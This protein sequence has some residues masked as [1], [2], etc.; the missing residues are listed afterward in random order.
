MADVVVKRKAKKEAENIVNNLQTEGKDADQLKKQLQEV[1]NS[2]GQQ[3][4]KDNQVGIDNLKDEL[5]K[6]VSDEEYSQ[7]IAG[8]VEKTLAKYSIKEDELDSKVEED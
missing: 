3:S 7:I 2:K 5:S 6:K 8:I 1:E 4:Y